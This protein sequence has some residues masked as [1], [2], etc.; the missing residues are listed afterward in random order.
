MIIVTGGA[1]FIGS[2]L[3][4]KL[5]KMQYKNILI[6]DNL[7]NNEKYN[8]IKDLDFIDYMDKTNFIKNIVK[9]KIS[10]NID[11]KHEFNKNIEAVFH[12]GACSSTTVC[13]HQYIIKNNYQF[14]KILLNFCTKNKIPFIYASSAAVYGKFP[15]KF[16]EHRKYEQPCN[17]YGFSKFFFDQYVRFIIPQVKSQ[18]CGL[19]YFNVYGPRESHKK[20]MASVIFQLSKQIKNNE[21]PKLFIGSKNFQRDF[22]HV[23]DIVKINIWAWENKASGIFNCGTGTPKSFQSIA[24]IVLNF[25]KKND[26]T[27][28]DVPNLINKQYQTFT[29]A[30]ITKIRFA[31]YKKTFKQIDMGIIEYLKWLDK[32]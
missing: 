8:N 11:N 22:I 6:V 5:N 3:I 27:Y 15:K 30:D 1:G 21:K 4:K 28:I 7:K 20:K 12:Q 25:Y 29:K 23:D 14:S 17:I 24:D 32:N 13:N 2:N 31:G 19:R 9:N 26:I 16:I 10:Y 18:I